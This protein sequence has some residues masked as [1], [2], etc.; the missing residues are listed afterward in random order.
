MVSLVH[1]RMLWLAVWPF[2]L[3]VC[4]WMVIGWAL[5]S[6]VMPVLH[7]LLFSM[8]LVRWVEG[9]VHYFGLDALLMLLVPMLYVTLLLSLAVAT[10]LFIIGTL[11][12]PIVIDHVAA[13][14][15]PQ[16][17]RR[18]GGGAV[19]SLANASVA[20]IGFL[21]G[22]IITMPLW[23]FVPLA[24]LLPWFWWGWLTRRVLSYDSLAIHADAQERA[25]LSQRYSRS[26]LLLGLG[27]AAMNFI[28]PLFFVAPI[29]GG[30]AF[31]HFSLEALESLR[32]E[33]APAVAS[34]GTVI[35]EIPA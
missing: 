4:L 11:A 21:C 24:F 3:S 17:E 15:H 6:T 18:H 34:S 19:S 13:R 20:V 8:T 16:L 14:H 33:Q 23:L 35:E 29:I 31:T 28:P 9:A 25:Q 30:L 1:P 2:L 10:A 12:M 26:Y 32:R 5:K 27:V 7:D 22:W